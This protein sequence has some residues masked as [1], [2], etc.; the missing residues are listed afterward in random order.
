[1]D[2]SGCLLAVNCNGQVLSTGS[3]TSQI[4]E[5]KNINIFDGFA[6]LF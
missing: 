1:M 3:C 5:K 2:L 6:S 4:S